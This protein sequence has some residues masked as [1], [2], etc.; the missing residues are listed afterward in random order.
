MTTMYGTPPGRLRGCSLK[1]NQN[2]FRKKIK[3]RKLRPKRIHKII[4]KMP[5]SQSPQFSPK[6]FAYIH[7]LHWPR[8][9]IWVIYVIFIKLPKVNNDLIGENSP[10]LVTLGDQS[11]SNTL[12]ALNIASRNVESQ[13]IEKTVHNVKYTKWPQNT[14]N[15][16]KIYQMALKYTNIFY[17]KALQ[18]IR[19]S[20][21]IQIWHLATLHKHPRFMTENQNFYVPSS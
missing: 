12:R 19:K 1:L 6:F 5:L 13:N 2:F 4:S 18:N 17:S 3:D 7:A 11:C 14:P 9:K 16:H 21:L 8:K 10:N 15:C 20:G